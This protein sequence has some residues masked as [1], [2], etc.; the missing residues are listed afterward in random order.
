MHKG[1]GVLISV[2]SFCV[3][4]L[5]RVVFGLHWPSD[6]LVGIAVGVA[7]AI[8]MLN[9]VKQ[10]ATEGRWIEKMV[11]HEAIFYPIMFLLTFQMATMFESS[12]QMLSLASSFA[13]FLLTKA[14]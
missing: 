5:P 4:L 3:V 2:Y 6:I 13:S 14:M 8:L 10:A 9:I 12:R 11:H 7:V 1:I